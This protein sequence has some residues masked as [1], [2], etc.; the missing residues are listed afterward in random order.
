MK[1]YLKPGVSDNDA[2]MKFLVKHRHEV[3]V[4]ADANILNSDRNRLYD[5]KKMF[6]KGPTDYNFNPRPQTWE[7]VYAHDKKI[8]D[9]FAELSLNKALS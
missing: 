3:E 4:H 8:A 6:L 7:D 9:Q 1:F 2:F 5:M